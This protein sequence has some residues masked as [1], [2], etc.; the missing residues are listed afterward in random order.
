MMTNSLNN[1]SKTELA[2]M[3]DHTFLKQDG[4]TSDIEKLCREAIEYK[5]CSVCIQPSHIR[6]AKKFMTDLDPNHK[7]K[8]CT[9]VGFP[10]GANETE[11]KAFEAKLAVQN[12]ANEIDMVI[13][14]GAL[15]EQNDALV[16]DDIKQVVSASKHLCT[17]VLVK[18][19]L[20]TCLLNSDEIKRACELSVKS[21]ADFVKTST[22]FS[23]NGATTSDVKLMRETVGPDIGVKASG[24]IRDYE[25]AL[26]M[27]EAGASRLGLSASIAILK[28]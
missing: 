21:G 10:G 20:E 14:I 24:G 22:G 2:S 11:T 27:I 4:L 19:I 26:K 17:S 3:I 7:V 25:N 18:V 28:G 6:H 16:A 23:T 5:F 1:I 8:L 15:K 12:G 9:V 13:N